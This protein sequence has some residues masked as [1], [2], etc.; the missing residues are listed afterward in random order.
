[1]LHP[2]PLLHAPSRA[3]Q[4]LVDAGFVEVAYGGA[5]QG[6]YLC[7]HKLVGH[8]H[9]TGSADTFDAIVWGDKRHNKVGGGDV[10]WR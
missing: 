4:P 1:M 2:C 10:A 9:L 7:S 5:E 6:K 8:I 3:L